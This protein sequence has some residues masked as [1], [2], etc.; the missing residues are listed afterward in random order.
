MTALYLSMG[1]VA[2]FLIG[3][4]LASGRKKTAD[5]SPIEA[6]L[7]R[8]IAEKDGA[9][10]AAGNREKELVGEKSGA[11]AE[12]DAIKT[13]LASQQAAH[14]KALVDLREA[15]TALSTEALKQNAPEFLR[16]A[17]D[18]FAKAREFYEADGR[19]LINA[20]IGGNLTVLPRANFDELF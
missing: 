19:R 10:A 13:M 7:R 8:Q 14:E 12:R 17:N 18:Q 4:L 9:L 15:F 5:N 11:A 1:A 16:L 6:E 2:G 20:G 3:W